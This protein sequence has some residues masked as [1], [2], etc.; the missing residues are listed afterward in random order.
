MSKTFLGRYYLLNTIKLATFLVEV[1][2]ERIRWIEA[3]DSGCQSQPIIGQALR[4]LM[5]LRFLG[6][7]SKRLPVYHMF[8]Q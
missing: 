2:M 7:D 4:A 1:C 3:K 6:Q 5:A 8:D